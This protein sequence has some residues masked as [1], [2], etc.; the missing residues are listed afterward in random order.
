MK[1]FT[2]L[3]AIALLC[4]ASVSTQANELTTDITS[5]LS[6]IISNAIANSISSSIDEI[7]TTTLESMKISTD[8]SSEQ[9]TVTKEQ[10][11]NEV[12]NHGE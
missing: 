9:A 1:T 12:A 8:F 10:T 7:T 2:K 6:N 11:P 4:G 5:E 3:T